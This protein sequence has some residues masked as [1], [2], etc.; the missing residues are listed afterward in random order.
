MTPSGEL[1][2]AKRRER[3]ARLIAEKRLAQLREQRRRE[4][5][6]LAILRHNLYTVRANMFVESGIT[7]NCIGDIEA[8][9]DDVALILRELIPVFKENDIDIEKLRALNDCFKDFETDFEYLKS[10][11]SGLKSVATR[12]ES[13]ADGLKDISMA[14]TVRE[15]SRP[16]P[17]EEMLKGFQESYNSAAR[18][19]IIVLDIDP[20]A[21]FFGDDIHYYA[22]LENLISNSVYQLKKR[23]IEDGRV[24]VR[25]LRGAEGTCIEVADSGPGTTKNLDELVSPFTSEQR[26][27]GK[28]LG[29]WIVRQIVELYSGRL[30][31]EG[32]GA[33][34]GAVFTVQFSAK[35]HL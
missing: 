18:K 1:R 9:L 6:I 16:V 35:R 8:K 33:L 2:G 10:G 7:Q 11:L 20:E 31:L 24:S 28:G 34:G 25:L 17:I 15:P 12:I 3:K 29:L 14:L 23:D 19:E 13:I 5:G 21:R 26:E 27:T 4:E 32:K 30:L 22:I